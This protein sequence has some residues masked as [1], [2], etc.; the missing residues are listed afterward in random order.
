[1]NNFLCPKCNG[2]L[3]VGEN[4]IFKVRN[5]KK[6]AGLVLL[7]PQIGN[8]NS[9]RHP[10]FEINEGDFL[11]FFC[12]LCGSSIQSDIHKN[13]AHLILQ[14]DN[15]KNHD[16]YFSQIQGE[17]STYETSGDSLRVAGENAGK[18]TYFKLGNKFKAY[19]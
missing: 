1:M 5:Q 19:L 8:Y 6:H 15:G 9:I 10:S 14:D 4:I 11:E 17:H 3:R 12:P 16:V 7:H 2:Q 13:L 18:Y